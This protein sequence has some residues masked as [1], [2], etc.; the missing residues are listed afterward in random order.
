[1]RAFRNSASDAE[2]LIKTEVPTENHPFNEKR[3]KKQPDIAVANYRLMLRISI[4][5]N[6]RRFPHWSSPAALRTHTVE[7][8]STLNFEIAFH[9]CASV[10]HL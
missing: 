10:F 2:I 1:V 7:L 5:N 6:K 4:T 9:S 3:A 8:I